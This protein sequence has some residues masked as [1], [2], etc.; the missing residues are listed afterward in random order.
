MRVL[1]T[2]PSKSCTRSSAYGSIATQST[3]SSPG[4]S[5]SNQDLAAQLGA[6]MYVMTTTAFLTPFSRSLSTTCRNMAA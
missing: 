5:S 1:F 3:T 6:P 2:S 4:Y